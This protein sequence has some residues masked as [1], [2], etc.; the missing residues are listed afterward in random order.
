MKE[1]TA[2]A[3]GAGNAVL[4]VTPYAGK[5]RRPLIRSSELFADCR[6]VLIEHSG[7][8]YS[9]RQTSKGKLILTK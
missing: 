7:E 2:P 8:F 1:E 3:A 6:E 5:P 9:L 4:P